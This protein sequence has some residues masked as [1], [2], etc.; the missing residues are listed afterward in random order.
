[1]LL[2]RKAGRPVRLAM[3]AFPDEPQQRE[4]PS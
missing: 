1:M 2:S 4:V 3:F